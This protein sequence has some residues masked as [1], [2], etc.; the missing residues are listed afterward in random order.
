MNHDWFISGDLP[1]L[2]CLKSFTGRWLT[3]GPELERSDTCLR[4]VTDPLPLSQHLPAPPSPQEQADDLR[5]L[6]G[7]LT[8]SSCQ[9]EH[10]GLRS[11]SRR[12]WD[13]VDLCPAL[14]SAGQ[15]RLAPT[16]VRA[17]YSHKGDQ[18]AA[19]S[20]TGEADR[21]CCACTFS[22]AATAVLCKMATTEYAPG[23]KLS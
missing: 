9:Q 21:F 14:S 6:L 18:G 3:R 7:D 19:D 23:H 17:A 10:S 12:W 11:A 2:C 5:P 22:P 20:D 8:S 15:D 1:R 4:V 13:L 16:A